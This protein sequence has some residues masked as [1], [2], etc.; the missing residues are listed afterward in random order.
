MDLN[1]LEVRAP[2]S[3][4]RREKQGVARGIRLRSKIGIRR[5]HYVPG[6]HVGNTRGEV[7]RV[8]DVHRIVATAFSTISDGPDVE[9]RDCDDDDHNTEIL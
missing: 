8:V 9:K 3:I 4:D 2:P 5:V 7:L 6:L 1:H